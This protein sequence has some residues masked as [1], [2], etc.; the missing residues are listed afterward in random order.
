[1]CVWGGCIRRGVRANAHVY[2][3]SSWGWGTE[4]PRV[5][6]MGKMAASESEKSKVQKGSQLYGT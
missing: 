5:R 1:M 4:D 6:K 3:M 2:L